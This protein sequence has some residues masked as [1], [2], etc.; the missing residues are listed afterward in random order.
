MGVEQ[1][2][3]FEIITAD[4]I[5]EFF[6][7]IIDKGIRIMEIF[8]KENVSERDFYLS[9]PF[10]LTLYTTDLN[11][12]ERKL[13]WKGLKDITEAMVRAFKAEFPEMLEFI[14]EIRK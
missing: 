1:K 6:Q 14:K 3:K 11:R 8:V 4:E 13:F 7:E 12:Q 5:D 10:F 2:N 9:I